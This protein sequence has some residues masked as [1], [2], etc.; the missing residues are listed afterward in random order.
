MPSPCGDILDTCKWEETLRQTQKSLG[1]LHI[2]SGLGTPQN[3]RKSWMTWLGRTCMCT[4]H[5]LFAWIWFHHIIFFFA[6]TFSLM[7]EPRQILTSSGKSETVTW[8]VLGGK[9]KVTYFI[10]LFGWFFGSQVAAIT[11]VSTINVTNRNYGIEMDS[12]K[13]PSL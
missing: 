12:Q 9:E 11:L 2:P 8:F 1:V 3:H 13:T 4:L 7:Q 6:T 5:M 10:I